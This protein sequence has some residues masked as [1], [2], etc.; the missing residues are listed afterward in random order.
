MVT[1]KKNLEFERPPIAEIVLSVHFEQLDSLLAPHF[2]VIWQEFKNDQFGQMIEQQPVPPVIEKF[3][4][5]PGG[6]AQVNVSTIP[7]LPRIWFIENNNNRILQVQ[8]DRF[9]YNWRKI[10]SEQRY[11]GFSSVMGSNGTLVIY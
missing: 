11:P 8:R 5:P 9:T 4:K 2:G 10:D 1:P 6:E 3:P 7:T